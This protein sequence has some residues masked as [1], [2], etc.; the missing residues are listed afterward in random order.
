M[1][2]VHS[3][4]LR[5][6]TNKL[7]VKEPTPVTIFNTIKKKRNK[8]VTIQEGLSVLFGSGSSHSMILQDL[9]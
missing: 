8:Y 4:E 9:V 3:N 5:M 6:S 7:G 2:E 1:N